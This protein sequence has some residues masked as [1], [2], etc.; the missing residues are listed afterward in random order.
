MIFLRSLQV[1]AIFFVVPLLYLLT[2]MYLFRDVE[3]YRVA[4]LSAI[5]VG[6]V[7]LTIPAGL[8]AIFLFRLVQYPTVVKPESPT[9][10]MGK[11]IVSLFSN[12]PIYVLGLPMLAAMVAFNKSMFELKPMIP[13]LNPFSWDQTFMQLDRTLHLGFDPWQILMPILGSDYITFL[14]NV[15]YNFWFLAL[16]GCFMWF[17]FATRSSV[18]RTQFFLSYMLAWWLG[19][20]VLAVTFSSA[21][22]VYY[23]S[24]GLSP[25]PFQSLMQHLRDVD[26]RLPIWS[27]DTQ[28]LLWD[29]YTGKVPA[30]GISAFPSMHNAST[31]LFALATWKKSRA[32]GIAFAIYTAIILLG[33]VHL[34]WHY[35]VDGY[36]GLALAAACW[37]VSGFI[38]RWHDGWTVTQ[39][40]NA[41][42]ATR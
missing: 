3:S 15:F 4:G 28:Q 35:A 25:D 26:T 12:W 36:A 13:V 16:F 27:L 9:R 34:G 18:N 1:H 17:G 41:Q 2:N 24:L 31:L 30:I 42:I 7:S 14:I 33:S 19:G 38:A 11:D 37:W 20:G 21:G 29:G 32:L 10:Q 8:A 39:S 40:L 23:S 22:P 5:V 6:M